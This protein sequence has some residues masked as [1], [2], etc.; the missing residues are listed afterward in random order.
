M[1][2]AELLNELRII[3]KEDYGVDVNDT[4][5]EECARAYLTF[6][7]FLAKFRQNFGK[8]SANSEFQLRKSK[9]QSVKNGTT[10]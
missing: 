6:G 3:L 10:K 7:E 4:E 2:S 5:L 9:L 1:L 8:S